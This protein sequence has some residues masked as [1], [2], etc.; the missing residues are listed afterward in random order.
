MEASV[1]REGDETYDI[2]VRYDEAF[3]K[4]INDILDI[5]VA[6]GNGVQIPLRDVATVTTTGGYGSINHID[7]KRT[8]AVS[9]DVTGR[10]SSEII[11]E[12]QKLLA[13]KLARPAGYGVKYTGETQEQD[14]ASAFLGK[15]GLIGL[16]LIA[17]ILITQ[18]NSVIRPAII[19]GSVL[20]SLI[21]V[22]LCL[23]ITQSK[24]SVIMSGIGIIALAGVVVKNAI[25]LIDYTNLLV[26]EQGL[27]LAEALARAGVVR[28]RPVILT[29]AAA[30]LGVLP[31]A[32]GVS[33]DFKHFAV[34]VGSSSAEMWGPL[35]QVL[36]FGLTFA[37]VLTLIVV[38]VMYVAQDNTK[39]ALDR[40]TRRIRGP[41]VKS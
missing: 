8:I 21:G 41:E 22:L 20:L 27:P 29:A 35:A 15:A 2:T 30:V 10:S 17:L 16:M 14:E 28:L 6:G 33:I 3:R 36:A 11:P 37:T 19:M 4:S 7:Q 25:V 31:V 38:P 5:R 40:L 12:I 24:F 13:A 34:D 32:F 26:E 9:S 18:F 39:N 23:L 1:L